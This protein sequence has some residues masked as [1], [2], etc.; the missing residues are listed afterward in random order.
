M[1]LSK[2]VTRVFDGE[3]G[4][5][6]DKL[7]LGGRR[8]WHWHR[9]I[10]L[11]KLEGRISSKIMSIGLEATLHPSVSLIN[12]QSHD[13]VFMQKAFVYSCLS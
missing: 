7:T 9:N 11:D 1:A 3:T 6:V 4:H 13:Y 8:R 12:S 10:T 2:T 5:R